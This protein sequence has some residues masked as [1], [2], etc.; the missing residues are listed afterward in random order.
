MHAVLTERC[1]Q[2]SKWDGMDWYG[3]PARPWPPQKHTGTSF[4]RKVIPVCFGAYL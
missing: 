3:I 4:L 1:P 2:S